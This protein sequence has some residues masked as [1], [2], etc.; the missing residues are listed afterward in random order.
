MR[1][2]FSLDE[3]RRFLILGSVDLIRRFNRDIEIIP[4]LARIPFSYHIL[5]YLIT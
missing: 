4:H 2:G 3:L 1:I 5:D